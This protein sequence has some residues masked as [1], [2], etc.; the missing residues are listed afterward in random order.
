MIDSTELTIY[1]AL[2]LVLGDNLGLN[3]ILGYV[4][5]FSANFYCR[6]CRSHK[7]DMQ[8][9]CVESEISIR[10]IQNYETDLATQN[11]SLTGI[12]EPSI[13][14]QIPYFHCT[15][16]IVCDFMHDIAEGVARY[17]MA[18][19]IFGIIEQKCFTL[20]ELNNRIIMFNYGVTEKKNSPP[21]IRD[22]DIK[23][24]FI[25]MSASEMLCFV[26]YF[27]LMVGELVPYE[28]LYWKL[29]HTAL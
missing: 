26:R 25:I 7:L 29:S 3:S 10:N 22:S 6:I 21:I 14:H 12:L 17:D 24:G 28:S 11:P 19:I 5:S 15:N 13:F 9:M 23:K 8:Q 1:F 27:C 16:N 2:G 20:E 4:S 18:L